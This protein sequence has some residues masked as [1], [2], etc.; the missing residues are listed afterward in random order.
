MSSY[1]K[2]LLIQPPKPRRGKTFMEPYPL[3]LAYVAAYLRDISDVRILSTMDQVDI[4]RI[5]REIEEFNP[6]LVGISISFITATD[7]AIRI[8]SAIKQLQPGLS[9]I[10]GGQAA[11]S[12]SDVLFQTGVFDM[13]CH[14]EGEMTVRDLV[15][16]GGPDG[17]AGLSFIRS[18]QITTNPRRPV[19][20]DLDEL[21]FPA[22][23]L[24]DYPL[25][26]LHLIDTS[27]G[28]P[29]DCTFCSVRRF[30]GPG[31]PYRT[32]SPELVV[33][34]IEYLIE[35]YGTNV[36]FL[37]DDN[38]TISMSHIENLCHHILD[39]ELK[40]GL[41]TQARADAIARH[42]EIVELMARAGFIMVALG[43][44]SANPKTLAL[45][46][47]KTEVE[48]G[49]RAVEILKQNGILT[50][51]LF[52]IGFPHEDD[53]L[54]NQTLEHAKQLDL[55]IY[56]PNVLTPF[57]GSLDYED[58]LR[59]GLLLDRKWVDYD[60]TRDS[61][62]ASVRP[63]MGRV[64]AD[65]I[66]DFYLRSD[67]ITNHFSGGGARFIVKTSFSVLMDPEGEQF[68]P[69]A[70]GQWKE[71]FI[72]W[73]NLANR[74]L[75]ASL[76]GY[77]ANIGFRTKNQSFTLIIQE[78]MIKGTEPG[79][80]EPDLTLR[81][82]DDTLCSLYASQTYDAFSGL[83]NRRIHP[84]SSPGLLLSWI[85]W[86]NLLQKELAMNAHQGP[87]FNPPVV[88]KIIQ[89]N[90]REAKGS[91]HKQGRGSC[92]LAVTG[93]P[94]LELQARNSRL[95]LEFYD[96]DG[97]PDSGIAV[98]DAALASFLKGDGA[99]LCRTIGEYSQG[100]GGQNLSLVAE[101]IMQYCQA[102]GDLAHEK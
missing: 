87:A 55:D 77:R 65:Q 83:F 43:L 8:A 39:R 70:F 89:K 62:I 72:A 34:K 79:Q 41:V 28:C 2:V 96:S 99:S 20:P 81:T 21:R 31:A 17:V 5:H 94:C 84:D 93:G 40:I 36:F 48:V 64:L 61:V 75:H 14:G 23:D 78:G 68:G 26:I 15:S 82:D 90:L 29:Y 63:D 35:H 49:V 71:L 56:N 54:M 12:I 9:I 3:G 27:R 18:G 1:E 88:F 59:A 47:K 58:Y 7:N 91:S 69:R 73:G 30:Y 86:T 52:I 67:W 57:P 76:P 10:A 46:Q 16:R 66:R 6:D 53:G 102:A 85:R 50:A 97:D 100:N 33:K 24:V 45:A 38:S 13:V 101:T 19:I 32:A 80:K 51:G 11:T 95:S 60:P 74:Q 98:P 22:Y 42:P 4:P 92:R 44:E 25:T 37:V